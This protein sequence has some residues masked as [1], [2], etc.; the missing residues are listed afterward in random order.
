MLLLSPFEAMLRQTAKV[1]MDFNAID[2][3]DA[4][5]VLLDHTAATGLP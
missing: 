1:P 5:H 4:T 2:L 3:Y